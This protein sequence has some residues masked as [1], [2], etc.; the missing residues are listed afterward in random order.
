MTTSELIPT[1]DLF[2]HPSRL[3]GQRHVARVMIHSFRLLEATG[4]HEWSTRLWASVYLHDLARTHDGVCLRH[5]ADAVTKWRTSQRLTTHLGSAGV[6]ADLEPSVC[7][8]VTLHCK[9]NRNEP[10]R[11][12]SDWPLVALLK[13]ADGLDRVRLGDLAPSYLRLPAS[14]SMVAFAQQLF[15]DTH[16]AI[17]EGPDLFPV[18]LDAAGDIAGRRIVVPSAL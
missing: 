17:P 15:D 8:A 1:P 6:H 12:D 5:G 14:Q 9:P 10:A 4:L 7:R 3:H 11:D 2:T 16:D 13:D 18:L